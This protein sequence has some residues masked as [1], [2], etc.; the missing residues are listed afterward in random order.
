MAY[1]IKGLQKYKYYW[2][3]EIP[4]LLTIITDM[5]LVMTVT[6][7]TASALNIMNTQCRQKTAIIAHFVGMY[8]SRRYGMV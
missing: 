6:N 1:I 4:V 7:M 8:I 5:R 3:S 2:S